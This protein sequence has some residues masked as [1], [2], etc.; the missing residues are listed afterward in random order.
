MA[1]WVDSLNNSADHFLMFVRLIKKKNDHVSVR[2]VENI[3]QGSKVKQKTVCGVGHFHKD[4]TK[5]IESAKRIGE[6]MIVKIKNE[7]RP[8]LPGLEAIVHTPAKRNKKDQEEEKIS[9]KYLTEEARIHRGVTDVYSHEYEQ[10]GLLNTFDSKYKKE[11][12]NNLLKHLVLARIDKPSSKRKSI[13]DIRRNKGEEYSLDSV[14]RL[15]DQLYE[16][17]EWVKDKVAKGTLSLFKERIKVAFFDVTTLY[18]ESFTPDDLRISGY[19]KDNK[20]KETQVVFALMTTTKG[21][22]LGY[23]LF[24]GNTYEGG[25]LIRA[26]DDLCKRYDV[27]DTSII[28][29]R[30]MFTESNLKF[31]EER[32]VHFVIS[33]KL[34]KMKKTTTE[35]ILND[36]KNVLNESNGKIENWSG[37]YEYNGRRLVVGYSDKRAVK[38]RSDRN[39]LVE[40]VK[41]KLKNGKVKAVDLVKNR[42]TKKYLKF[43]GNKEVAILDEEKIEQESR[44]DGVYGIITS[45]NKSNV[46]G[47]E[48]FERY[49]GLW[50]IEDAFRVNK[51]DLKMRP[52][53]HW[54]PKRVKSHIL[55]CYMSYA[56]VASIKYKLEKSNLSLSID[57]I[58]EELGYVQASVV[59]DRR[60]GKRF[61]LPS[62]ANNTQR[63]IYSALGL[64]LQEKVQYLK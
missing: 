33:A 19:S 28:A 44:W 50:Q 51:H 15:M 34:K 43:S 60:S 16:R 52:I 54:S 5:A 31:L 58:R 21:L 22:P 7:I 36:I 3:K 12:K 41:K 32:G 61:L 6:E 40:R 59:R 49:R 20:V 53:F 26:V 8:A 39:R 48:V 9:C 57:R 29:D 2:I 46:S 35:N 42:G 25:T 13:K 23:E 24:P 47:N 30:A 14:Y 62:K 38:D 45:H 17:E 27:V 55:I 56:L 10:L 1:L 64:M 37:E 63:A 18:F 11:E 4:N